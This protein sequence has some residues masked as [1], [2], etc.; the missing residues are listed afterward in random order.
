MQETNQKLTGFA[1]EI[2]HI[3]AWAWILAA[4]GFL[5]MQFVF[6]VVV[7]HQPDAP[8]AWARPLIGLSVG[9]VVA[10]YLLMI[11]YVNRDFKLV[12]SWAWI[13][14]AIGFLTM[15]FV[16]NVVIARQHDAPPAWA[17][18]LLG[19]LVGLILTCYLLLIGYVN[20]DAGRRGMSRALWTAVS[21]LVPNGLG[22]ILYFILRQPIVGN[23]PQCGHGVQHGF[24]FC[25]QCNYK[26]NPS[27]PQCQRIIRPEDTYCHFCG[28]AV[29]DQAVQTA[30]AQVER[31]AR[32]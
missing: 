28:T 8:P 12:A 11:G 19:L 32:S 17:R 30:V 10:F 2:R 13:L 16:F 27:C 23:C 14:A 7:A 5:S 3:A 20:R 24:N 9:I 15:Q 25:P 22:I 26:L 31:S 1:A 6:N 18:I 4:I 29:R 21:V